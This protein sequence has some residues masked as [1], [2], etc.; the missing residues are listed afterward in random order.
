MSDNFPKIL[1]LSSSFRVN[2]C[3]L[4]N[5]RFEFSRS[6]SDRRASATSD[7]LFSYLV[8]VP[9]FGIPIP[10]PRGLDDPSSAPNAVS[11]W[12]GSGSNGIICVMDGISETVMKA[13]RM[14]GVSAKQMEENE[15][16][17]MNI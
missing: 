11:T 10:D 15:L 17:K 12:C 16:V 1:R 5:L 9:V 13:A 7:D 6:L 2:L 14:P 8:A 3:V 4:I